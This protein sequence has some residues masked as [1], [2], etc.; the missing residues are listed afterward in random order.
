MLSL[1]SLIDHSTTQGDAVDD[2]YELGLALEVALDLAH[3]RMA[4]DCGVY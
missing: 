4:A 2:T 1:A 3:L